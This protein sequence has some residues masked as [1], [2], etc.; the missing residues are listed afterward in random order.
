MV[1]P[2]PTPTLRALAATVLL[3]AGDRAGAQPPTAGAP[4]PAAPGVAPAG[5]DSIDALFARWS[6]PK[7]P[8][9]AVAAS[10]DGRPSFSRAYG[11]ANLDHHVPN[12][13]TTVF[14]TGSVAKQFAAAALLLLAEDGKLSLGDDVRRYVPELPDYGTVITID[15]LLTH[16]SGLREG[17]SVAFLGGWSPTG[18]ADLLDVMARQRALN[19]RP[20]E[21]FTYVGAGFFLASVIV[22]RVSGESLAAFSRRRM[23][24][25][26]GMNATRWRE[27]FRAVVSDRATAYQSTGEGYVEAMPAENVYGHGGLLTTVGDLLLWNDALASGRLGRSVSD[28]LHA[29]GRLADGRPTGYGR[30]VY[31]GEYGGARE[32]F[33]DGGH[34]GYRAW[35]GRYPESRL[36]IALLCN[37]TVPDV[38]ALARRV[39]DVL[40]PPRVA[41]RDAPAPASAPATAAAVGMTSEEARRHAGVFLSDE[42]GLPLVLTSH[43]ARL[44]VDGAPAQRISEGRF[45]AGGLEIVFET[46]GVLRLHKRG[47]ERQTLRRVEGPVPTEAALHALAGRYRSDEAVATYVAGVENGRLVLRLDGRPAYVHPLTAIGPDVFRGAGMVVRFH[48]DASGRPGALAFTLP[49]VRELRF[50]RLPS[51]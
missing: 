31:V 39:A 48:R 13:S 41:E 21:Q 34:G 42:L 12:T 47:G 33:H 2:P 3:L 24:A 1:C 20:G 6:S 50:T 10:R 51:P 26:L 22:K 28:A 15:H 7:S 25:P 40:L 35:L 36:S 18:E 45:R 14:E 46:P 16:T 23:F 17:H 30:G 29:V 5:R 43:G 37:T 9:C 32:V 44:L 8:G 11:M 27:N 19:H 38:T 49:R 4:A